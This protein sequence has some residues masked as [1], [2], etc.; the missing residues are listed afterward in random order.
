ML[1]PSAVIPPSAIR[2]ACTSRTTVIARVAVHGTHQ[3]R[4]Q[5]ATQQVAGRA[6]ADREVE[7]LGGED[8]QRDEP[9]ERSG[10]VVELATGSAQGQRHPGRGD[11]GGADRR[12]CVEE[13]VGDVHEVLLPARVPCLPLG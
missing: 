8:E 10:A 6:R 7:H 12:R 5:G 3:D 2:V 9:G 11:D 13:S 1:V 4:R